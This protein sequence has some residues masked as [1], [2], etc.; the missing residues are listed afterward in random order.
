MEEVWSVKLV[1][2]GG[3]SSYTPELFDGV[4]TQLDRLPVREIVLVDIPEG[5]RKTEII[6][7]L[8]ERMFKE[9]GIQVR[10][11]HTEN[12]RE[13]LSGADFVINQ[14]R[15]GGLQARIKDEEIPLRYGLIGQETTG[16]GGF[17]K[18]LRTVPV[19]LEIARDMEEISP[20]A[21]LIN[22]TN[23]AGII[24]EALLRHSG[25]KA[26][27]LC[28][29]PINMEMHLAKELGVERNEL[30][31]EFIGLNHLSWI[32]QV[33]HKG[34]P[35]L[36]RI[37]K[38]KVSGGQQVVSNIPM[39]EDGD[40]II[41]TLELLPSPYLDYYY[42]EQRM[43]QKEQK[44]IESGEGTRG[45]QVKHLEEELFKLYEDDKLC[46]KPEQLSKRGGAYYSHV[47]LSLINALSKSTGEVHVIN[48]MN[49][50]A[51]PELPDDSV[52]ETNTLVSSSGVRPIVSG[53]LP[54]SVRGLIQHVK[55]YEELTVTAAVTGSRVL[56]LEALMAHPLIHGYLQAKKVLE[57]L[58]AAHRPYL[59]NFFES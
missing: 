19:A 11:S 28:N 21:W 24:T 1:I 51:F 39:I 31:C 7:S 43:I 45:I 35:I 56:A 2:I 57:D 40:E 33:W 38:H 29:V 15:V 5:R 48:V 6:L 58:L 46:R 50:G 52:V 42:W 13:A 37:I 30:Y 34:D 14:I 36:D 23:P 25:I 53:P 41:R 49:R 20:A 55:T 4:I 22:F 3:G 16:A 54:V 12:R 44:A 17:A 8:G 9:A 26:V 59:P 32:K 27:G 10:L 47:A 18:A